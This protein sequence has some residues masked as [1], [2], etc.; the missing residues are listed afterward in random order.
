M[1]FFHPLAQFRQSAGPPSPRSSNMATGV[2]HSFYQ[3]QQTHFSIP[4]TTSHQPEAY[5]VD[6]NSESL[7][8]EV[9]YDSQIP[10]YQPSTQFQD[11]PSPTQSQPVERT[12]SRRGKRVSN[13]DLAPTKQS[14]SRFHWDSRSTATLI[15][16]KRAHEID[17]FNLGVG[18]RS[19]TL[20]EQWY[21]HTQG[22]SCAA[23]SDVVDDTFERT[24]TNVSVAKKACKRTH[25]Y[26]VGLK[27]ATRDIASVLEAAEDAKNMGFTNCIKFDLLLSFSVLDMSFTYFMKFLLLYVSVEIFG[28]KKG[29][30]I[31]F[32]L[33]LT[34]LTFTFN[35]EYVTNVVGRALQSRGAEMK[36]YNGLLDREVLD[37][38]MLIGFLLHNND[39][40]WVA[41]KKI[42]VLGLI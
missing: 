10:S 4:T 25:V 9:V 19:K 41:L 39:R 29:C 1:S 28:I 3:H 38:P 23:P 16:V 17:R 27:E 6:L 14:S 35:E 12:Q 37:D 26:D 34:S 36:E 13:D 24:P 8:N 7:N 18:G 30:Y 32:L 20:E 42:S 21:T 33:W 31:S 15:E 2:D 11:N 22:V 40:R 5:F